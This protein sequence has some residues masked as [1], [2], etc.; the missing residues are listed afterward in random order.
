MFFQLQYALRDIGLRKSSRSWRIDPIPPRSRSAD[1]C[2]VKKPASQEPI[3]SELCGHRSRS[4]RKSAHSLTSPMILVR[5]S[6]KS[7]IR[8]V[9]DYMTLYFGR[10]AF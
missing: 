4:P 2:P 6:W 9:A 10:Y 5:Q 7:E 8:S 3:A 1:R